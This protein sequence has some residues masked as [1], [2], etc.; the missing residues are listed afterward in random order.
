MITRGVVIAEG[1]SEC[2]NPPGAP[3]YF[4]PQSSLYADQFLHPNLDHR[5][6]G[7]T[8]MDSNG[9]EQR[10]FYRR[11]CKERRGQGIDPL[12]PFAFFVDNI[13]V[14]SVV[15]GGNFC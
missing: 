2:G 9:A 15:F 7:L 14:M 13:S 1:L 5:Y 12:R 6:H 11:E 8:R 10:Q 4:E 3:A